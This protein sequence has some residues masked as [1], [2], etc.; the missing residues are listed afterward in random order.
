VA[1]AFA[2][3]L[4]Y[5][6]CTGRRLQRVKNDFFFN[7]SPHSSANR[8]IVRY[9]YIYHTP[10]QPAPNVALL[11]DDD[12]NDDGDDEDGDVNDDKRLSIFSR[13]L[14]LRHICI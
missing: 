1:A 12:D 8:Y 13:V 3:N 2:K 5:S 6:R 4:M 9:I 10:R 7:S 14:A 11:S